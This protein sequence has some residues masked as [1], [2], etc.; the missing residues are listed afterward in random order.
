MLYPSAKCRES[1]VVSM[2]TDM[3]DITGFLSLDIRDGIPHC[4]IFRMRSSDGL[5]PPKHY[6]RCLY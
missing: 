6:N 3:L 4:R 2:Q 5:R 1:H